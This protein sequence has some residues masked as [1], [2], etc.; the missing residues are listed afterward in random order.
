MNRMEEIKSQIKI[1]A[2]MNLFEPNTAS[3]RALICCNIG[4]YLN[5]VSDTLEQKKLRR[6]FQEPGTPEPTFADPIVIDVCE[7]DNAISFESAFILDNKLQRL[8]T[9]L[10]W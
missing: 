2:T 5:T 6:N 3:A 10:K 4:D 9:K 7:S 8:T 1:I